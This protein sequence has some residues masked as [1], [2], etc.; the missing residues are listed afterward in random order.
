MITI[1][2]PV[3]LV[4]VQVTIGWVVAPLV[5]PMPPVLIVV[6]REIFWIADLP[7]SLFLIIVFFI[8]IVLSLT[9]IVYIIG[10]GRLNII[11][12]CTWTWHYI[13]ASRAI[14]IAE[15]ISIL[16]LRSNRSY[17]EIATLKMSS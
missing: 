4:L 9:L 5:C 17:S 2:I 7:S 10:I 13:R 12:L 14:A 16:L 11:I 6:I 3:V 1:W 8:M 15:L